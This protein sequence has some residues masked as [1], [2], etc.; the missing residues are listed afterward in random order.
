MIVG[1]FGLIELF[2]IP[3]LRR[4]ATMIAENIGWGQI[5]ASTRSQERQS[6][7]TQWLDPLEEK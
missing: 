5:R 1:V 4:E 2:C 6:Q 3:L 7:T